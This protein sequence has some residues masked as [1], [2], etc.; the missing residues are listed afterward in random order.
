MASVRAPI[1]LLSER[2]INW[3]G[4]AERLIGSR[5]VQHQTRKQRS[6][7]SHF[8]PVLVQFQV[9]LMHGFYVFQGVTFF[10]P[11]NLIFHLVFPG[12]F[13]LRVLPGAAL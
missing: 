7:P 3:D 12:C 10:K 11:C 4:V 13:V 1:N 6:N 5:A 2:P 8:P 9:K